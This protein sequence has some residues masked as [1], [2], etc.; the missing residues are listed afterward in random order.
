MKAIIFRPADILFFKPTGWGLL[1][2]LVKA[3]VRYGHVALYYTETKRGLPLVIESIGRGV[4][5]RS[6]YCYSGQTV[7]VMRANLPNE[8]AQDVAKQA[9]HL[10]D[11]PASWYGY[12][13]IPRFVLP[14]LILVKAGAWLPAKWRLALNLLAGSYRQNS[15]YICS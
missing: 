8:K 10:A 14:K 11:N 4:V 9:E 6:L 13:D 15:F 2:P 1:T 3:L 5:I 7:Q 12:S